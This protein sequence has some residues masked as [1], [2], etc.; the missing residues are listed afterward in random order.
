MTQAVAA[1]RSVADLLAVV[2]RQAEHAVDR[3]DE[4]AEAFAVSNNLDTEAAFRE[5]AESGRIFAAEIPP[6]AEAPGPLPAWGDLYPEISDPD[7]VHYLMPPWHAFDL[8]W[9][10]EAQALALIE[11]QATGSPDPLIRAAAAELAG[12]QQL[13]VEAILARRDAQ[14]QPPPGWWEDQDGPNWDSEF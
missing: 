10:H 14:P 12:R 7:S 3:Y 4:L 9:R 5:L 2:R 13:R 11:A 1:V 8:A 6:P